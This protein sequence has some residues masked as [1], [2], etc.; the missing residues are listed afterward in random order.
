MF[1]FVATAISEVFYCLFNCINKIMPISSFGIFA[2]FLMLANYLLIITSFPATL[3]N[4][5]NFNA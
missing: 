1:S 5:E 2:A 3:I 4:I